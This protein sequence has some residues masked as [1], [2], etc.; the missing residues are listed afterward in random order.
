MTISE[1]LD[2]SR[3]ENLQAI[4]SNNMYKEPK[5]RKGEIDIIQTKM[6]TMAKSGAEKVEA[7]TVGR[8]SCAL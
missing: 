1:Q 8:V 5:V 3:V 2:L 6:I 4:G 7:D